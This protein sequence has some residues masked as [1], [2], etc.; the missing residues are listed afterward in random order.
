VVASLAGKTNSIS[1]IFTLDIYKKFIKPDSTERHLVA[2][3]KIAVLASCVLAIAII[4]FIGIDKKGGFQYIQ[5]YTGFVSPGI[6]SIFLLGFFWRRTT[7][8]A[9]IASAILTFILSTVLKFAAPDLP[10]INRMGVVFLICVAAM[11]GISL[12]DNPGRDEK[13]KGLDIQPSMFRVSPGFLVGTVLVLG[14]ITALYTL[15]W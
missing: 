1:T 8:S 12:F 7:S 11:V 15:F 13:S 3:G 6:L 2:V 4:P 14:I 5:E 10:F 9:A